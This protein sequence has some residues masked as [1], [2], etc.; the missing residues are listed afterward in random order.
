M[1]L[2][3][4]TK[5]RENASVDHEE[6]RKKVALTHTFPAQANLERKRTAVDKK[7]TN[8]V[9]NS[10]KYVYYHPGYRVRTRPSLLETD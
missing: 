7:T 3:G 2:E 10:N 1:V 9:F 4:R 8:T 6:P 5:R